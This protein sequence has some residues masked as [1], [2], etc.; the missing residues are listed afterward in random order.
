MRRRRAVGLATIAVLAVAIALVVVE[1]GVSLRWSPLVKKRAYSK[2]NDGSDSR[3][4]RTGASVSETGTR[5]EK[6]EAEATA[7]G[8]VALVEGVRRAYAVRALA[9]HVFSTVHFC[10][11]NNRNTFAS[12]NRA[13]ELYK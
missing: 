3:G 12:C 11:W 2:E 7:G 5:E 8:G 10:F 4:D 9:V 1:L 13:L 6:E